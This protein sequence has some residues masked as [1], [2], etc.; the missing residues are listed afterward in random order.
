MQSNVR[1]CLTACYASQALI[2]ALVGAEYL[3]PCLGRMDDA[4]KGGANEILTMQQIVDSFAAHR[5][6]D[7]KGTNSV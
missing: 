6:Y 2:A 7:N 4:G 1:V 3:A 5:N